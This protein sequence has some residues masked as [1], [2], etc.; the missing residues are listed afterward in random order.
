MGSWEATMA[1]GIAGRSAEEYARRLLEGARVV[2]PAGAGGLAAAGVLLAGLAV[3][4]L[5]PPVLPW[6]VAAAP[7]AGLL[8]WVV[9]QRRLDVAAALAVGVWVLLSPLVGV[10]VAPS[11]PWAP[12][13][14]GPA[15]GRMG[16]LSAL[17]AAA[18][19]LAARRRPGQVWVTVAAAAAAF[20]AVG[21]VAR[22]AAPSMVAVGAVGAAAVVVGGRGGGW[23]WAVGTLER[24]R[25]H[26]ERQAG[27]WQRGAE[28]E[29]ATATLLEA[30]DPAA[31]RIFHDRALPGT[32]A[33][34]DHL[35]IAPTGV[36]VV[37]SK[38]WAGR[39][40]A[41]HGRFYYRGEDLAVVLAPAGAEAR[42]VAAVLGVM[43]TLVVCVHGGPLPGRMLR[44]PLVDGTAA[45][46]VGPQ[47][48]LGL[49]T[50]RGRVLD[51]K[52]VHRLARHARQTL[53][54]A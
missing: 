25:V 36:F 51:S 9:R 31:F 50:G 52:Q 48:L 35:V 16:W 13:S 5:V 18:A 47:D 38:N 12:G 11:P 21:F 30:L 6:A 24:R 4:R 17:T 22:F 7:L 3:G 49:L 44:V 43:P 34:L 42:A 53:R 32:K 39:V 20:L 1:T 27:R 15:A 8:V 33:N 23:R 14:P 10:L 28:G 2:S 46:V 45:L 40:T 37:D 19:F 29:R 54:A 26:L 41:A